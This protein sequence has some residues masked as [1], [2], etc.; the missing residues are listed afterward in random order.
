MLYIN[1]TL[2]ISMINTFIFDYTYNK[3]YLYLEFI[4]ILR[5]LIL[6]LR[7]R[8]RAPVSQ[9]SYEAPDEAHSGCED[10]EGERQREAVSWSRAGLRQRPVQSKVRSPPII[11][12]QADDP[13]YEG[14]PVGRPP[15]A[16]W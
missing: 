5:N 16:S 6:F 13:L 7:A 10:E 2:E 15:R 11:R 3:C 4:N 14:T 12:L 8:L 1:A 9:G